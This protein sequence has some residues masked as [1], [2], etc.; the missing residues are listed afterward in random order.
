MELGARRAIVDDVFMSGASD[1]SF[2]ID[3][4]SHI[5]HTIVLLVTCVCCIARCVVEIDWVARFAGSIFITHR[6][7]H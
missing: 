7:V 3:E 5:I 2:C 4:G 6:Q 1:H